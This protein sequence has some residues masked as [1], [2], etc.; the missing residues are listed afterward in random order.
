MKLWDILSMENSKKIFKE[1]LYD[2]YI[3]TSFILLYL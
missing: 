3:A 1:E 2:I